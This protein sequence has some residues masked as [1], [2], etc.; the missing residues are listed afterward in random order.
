MGLEAV[1]YFVV[2]TNDE[3]PYPWELH[4]GNANGFMDANGDETKPIPGN[5]KV[6]VYYYNVRLWQIF[7]SR[8]NKIR[9]SNE[10]FFRDLF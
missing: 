3:D 1:G 5:E 7:K 4:V 8:T 10:G 6:Y 9:F 2:P